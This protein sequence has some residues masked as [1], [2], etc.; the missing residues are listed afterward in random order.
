MIKKKLNIDCTI[1]SNCIATNIPR[2]LENEW[3]FTTQYLFGP[4]SPT[5]GQRP[6]IYDD[7]IPLLPFQ[8]LYDY[9]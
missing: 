9:S 6:Y 5:V 3:T 4:V 8:T 7:R 1:H 2:E